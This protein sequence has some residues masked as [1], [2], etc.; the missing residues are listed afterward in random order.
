MSTLPSHINPANLA[1]LLPWPYLVLSR[2]GLVIYANEHAGRLFDCPQ[3]SFADKPLKE[4]FSHDGGDFS[5]A[6]ILKSLGP[7]KAWHGRW[8]AHMGEDRMPME[9]TLKCDPQDSDILW[10]IVMEN[11]VI[12][13]TMILSSR[14]ELQLLQLLMDHTLDY[15]FFTDIQGQFIITN[16]AFQDAIKVAYPGFEIGRKLEEF[17]SKETYRQF[18]VTDDRVLGTHRPLVNHVSMFRLR[19]GEGHWVQTTKVP[20]FDSKRQCVGLVCVSRDITELKE[21]NKKMR[22]AMRRSEIANQAKSDFLANMSHE[23]RTPINGIIGMTELAL[24][25]PLDSEQRDYLETVMKCTQTLLRIVND[26]LDFSKIEAGEMTI[27]NIEFKVADIL[28]DAIDQFSPLARNKGLDYAL[29]IASDVPSTVKGDPTRLKQLLMNLLNN[30]LK[31]TEEGHVVMSAS[32]LRSADTTVTLRFS[33]SDT[34]IGIPKDRHNSIFEHFTQADTSTTRNYGGTGLGLAICKQLVHL[35]DGHIYL[36]SR[37]GRGSTFT[38]EIPF[39]LT[40]SGLE[41][42]DLTIPELK[43]QRV[44][45]AAP[46]EAARLCIACSFRNLGM[47]ADAIGTAREA[48]EIMMRAHQNEQPYAYLL[49]DQA[50]RDMNGIEFARST[51]DESWREGSKILLMSQTLDA[52]ERQAAHAAG[53]A[54]TMAKPLKARL[55]NY[56]MQELL[57][58]LKRQDP[59]LGTVPDFNA[60]IQQLQVLLAEDNP[61][62]QEVASRR[63]RKLGHEVTIVGNGQ[64]AIDAW[65]GGHFDLILMDVQMP[66]MDG[67][68]A[69]KKIR[70]L[71]A[72]RDNGR[73][74]IIAMTARS[75]PEDRERCLSVGMDEYI[76]KPFQASKIADVLE[77]LGAGFADSD[78]TMDLLA[79]VNADE[80]SFHKSIS[81]LSG[82]SREDMLA[83]AE[84]YK[85]NYRSDL[86]ALKGAVAEKNI[87]EVCHHAHKIRGGLSALGDE[88]AAEMAESLEEGCQSGQFEAVEITLADLELKMVTLA[89]EI[90]TML[91]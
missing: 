74:A 49:L 25:T 52:A 33:I 36:N 75:L 17:V 29:S 22:Q 65:R 73:V 62:N 80:F 23:V 50:L 4:F 32:M 59:S 61:V 31:F 68:E 5:V 8:I 64:E 46:D 13:D 82:E 27:E 14:S 78:V 79:Q 2:S 24:D 40:D 91:Q 72:E 85:D 28:E 21:N 54:R 3:D 12:N 70:E 18:K 71:E 38:L 10:L 43:G 60:P 42:E 41:P 39:E 55:L 86:D 83:A 53:I 16:R 20:V 48:R 26:I 77:R 45:I 58:K 84:V 37:P 15:V 88:A 56:I 87:K 63:I 9:L 76:A 11:P 7:D 81:R 89:E 35:M 57:G 47:E 66:L 90:E 1:E 19:D 67:L 34:G 6:D 30:G 44:L 51:T 69:T